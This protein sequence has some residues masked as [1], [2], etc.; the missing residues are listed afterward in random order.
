MVCV[1]ATPFAEFFQLQFF[2]AGFLVFSRPIG[3]PFAN[4]ALEFDKIVLT[5][6]AS[7]IQNSGLRI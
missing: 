6:K 3:N 7:L 1:L 4:R 5:H 2:L